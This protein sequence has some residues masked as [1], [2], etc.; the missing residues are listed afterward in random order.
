MRAKFKPKVSLSPGEQARVALMRFGLGPKPGVAPR[1]AAA[2]GAAFDACMEEIFNPS[3]LLIPDDQVKTYCTDTNSDVVLDYAACCRLGAAFKPLSSTG[4]LPQPSQVIN[5]EK[6]ARYAKS[7]E[8]DVGF[9]ERLVHFWS[10]HFSVFGSKSNL[11]MATAGHME[12]NV[13]R[14]RVLGKFSDLLKAVYQHPTMISYLENQVSIGPNSPYAKNPR[15][16]GKNPDINENLARE[17]LELHTLGID[18]GHTQDDVIALAKILTGW[19]HYPGWVRKGSAIVEHD[20]AG[21]FYFEQ[22]YHEPYPQ[23]VLGVTYGQTGVDQGLAVLDALAKHPATA[24]H[25]AYKL[26]RHFV[27]DEPPPQLVAYLARLFRLTGG[28]LQVMAKALICLPQF[29]AEPMKR[30]VQPLPW[31][32]SV[33]RGMGTTKE[34]MLTRTAAVDQQKGS[35]YRNAFGLTWASGYLS[36]TM[37]GSLTPDGYPDDNFCWMNAKALRVRKDIAFHAISYALVNGRSPRPPDVIAA[38]LLSGFQ[39]AANATAIADLMK[40]K[41]NDKSPLSMLFAS[42]EYILR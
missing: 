1:L 38:D 39:S 15:N 11:V 22:D 33:I 19:T 30:M 31:Q 27:A 25:V 36:H 5:A 12:R 18:G 28:D 2:D 17:I 37:W 35:D 3:A 24:Q 4:F 20:L 8:P 14:P 13:I 10:N 34:T 7:L 42:P 23:K 26:I 9:A 21:Q 32:L 41:V 40:K 6:A 16:R 29:W